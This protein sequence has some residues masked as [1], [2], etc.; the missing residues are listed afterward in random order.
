[1]RD[2]ELVLII[3]PEVTEEELPTVVEKVNRFVTEGG[4]VV[5][6][7]E[8]MGRRKLAYPI[9][10][11]GEGNYILGQL[12]LEPGAA[13]GLE[14]NLRGSKEILRHLLVIM[15]GCSL[16]KGGERSS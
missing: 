8:Q 5:S 15:E 3:H 10:R 1:M 16:P 13:A 11:C 7:T 6:E 2:Y 4:G 14:A 9:K 12:K